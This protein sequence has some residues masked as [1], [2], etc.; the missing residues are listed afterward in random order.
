MKWTES[1]FPFTEPSLEL[2]IFFNG[3]WLE[4]RAEDASGSLPTVGVG[5][6]VRGNASEDPAKRQTRRAYRVR[7]EQGP[8]LL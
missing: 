4:V 3:K 2:E 5:V 8:P 1:Y 7:P 6:G